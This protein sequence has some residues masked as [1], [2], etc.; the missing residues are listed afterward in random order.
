MAVLPADQSTDDVAKPL[1]KDA[2]RN[3]RRIMA[4]ARELFAAR[5]L[6]SLDEVAAHAGVG[7]GTVYRRFPSRDD[8]V[9]ALFDES[10][11]QIIGH[12]EHAYA[13]AE[14]EP[15][16]A[17]EHF[18][19]RYLEMHAADRSLSQV[20]LTDL[21]GRHALELKKKP[22][23][24]HVFALVGRCKEAGAVRDDLD[25]TDVPML[26]LMLVSLMNASRDAA[27]DLWRRHLRLALDGLRPGGHPLPTP[28]ATPEQVPL[29]M[30][31]AFGTR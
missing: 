11:D 19:T 25:P 3:R 20:L 22:L 13:L 30:R 31:G 27:P 21:H 2:E 17:L 26:L 23:K 16:A 1:R 29:V 12:A 10:V 7:V 15:F 28:A 8:L 5:G 18:L 9:D 4:A 24:P 6:T 14:R